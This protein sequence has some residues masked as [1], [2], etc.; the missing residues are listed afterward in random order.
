MGQQSLRAL[1]RSCDMWLQWNKPTSACVLKKVVCPEDIYGAKM[2]NLRCYIFFKKK[3][4]LNTD[5]LNGST[6]LL[7]TCISSFLWIPECC[8]HMLQYI[9]SS[10][11]GHDFVTYLFSHKTVASCWVTDCFLFT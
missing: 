6:F 4:F 5:H 8:I 3:T 9:T 11:E 10:S 2:P 1:G 7:S